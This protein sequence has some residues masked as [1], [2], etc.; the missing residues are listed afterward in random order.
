MTIGIVS[1]AFGSGQAGL[2]VRSG[3]FAH[4]SPHATI[5]IVAIA[6]PIFVFLAFVIAQ[7]ALTFIAERVMDTAVAASARQV[8][9][10]RAGAAQ[11]T[12]ADIRGAFCARL[13]VFMNCSG[14][15]LHLDIRSYGSIAEIGPGRPPNG[16]E[17]EN[18]KAHYD[19]GTLGDFVVIR[20][21]Y[22][23]NSRPIYRWLFSHRSPA[24]ASYL[25]AFAV[26]KKSS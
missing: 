26:F 8:Q 5:V 19:L 3:A 11:L 25:R 6:A 22:R 10:D 24:P 2:R 23:W 1:N 4:Q 18:V 20:A 15:R 17:P 12:A 14:K 21:Y 16:T 13:P 7:T 9:S